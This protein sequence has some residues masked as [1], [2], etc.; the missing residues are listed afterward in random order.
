MGAGETRKLDGFPL[1]DW[2]RLILA[3]GVASAHFGLI[4][5]PQAGNLAVQ[6]FFALS[7][8]LIGTI[9]IEM[10]RDKLPLFYFNRATRVWVPYAVAV[11]VLYGLSVLRDPITGRWFEFLAYDAT[12]T[13]NWFTLKPTV[14]IARAQMPL[15]GTGNHFWSLAVEEQFYLAAPLLILFAPGGRSPWFWLAAAAVAIGSQSH[16][17]AI[18]LGVAAA[19]AQHRR[20][21]F[22]QGPGV[23]VALG[24]LVAGSVA[25]LLSSDAGYSYAIAAPLLSIAVVLLL[26]RPGPRGALGAFAGGI[27]YPLYLNHWIG[28]FAVHGVFKRL[29]LAMPVLEG[30]V[31]LSAALAVGM[32]AYLL[33]DRPLLAARGR[34][35]APRTGWM[36]AGIA[37][38]LLAAGVTLGIVMG[39]V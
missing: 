26:A 28:G 23:Q 34:W 9:L 25:A 5:W 8:W 27:S 37:Y 1:F 38:A 20:P 10:R 15:G 24:L 7:G 39:R 30:L 14:E 32:A 4:A 12:F 18:A 3:A 13:H 29:G 21:G 17:G 6:V 22:A 16:F 11:A 36:L 31:G 2:L 35:Y 19:A 33:V